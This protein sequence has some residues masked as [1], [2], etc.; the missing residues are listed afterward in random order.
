LPFFE[1]FQTPREEIMDGTC[2]WKICSV[3]NLKPV[4]RGIRKII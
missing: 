3:R 4:R 2:G 1:A